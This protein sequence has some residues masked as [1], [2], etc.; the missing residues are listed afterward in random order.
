MWWQTNQISPSV[1]TQNP[2]HRLGTVIPVFRDTNSA[3]AM[4][5][6]AAIAITNN[7]RVAKTTLRN[8][9]EK[10]TRSG[11]L[12]FTRKAYEFSALNDIGIPGDLRYRERRE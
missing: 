3:M 11:G 7:L 1:Q 10:G 6:K 2:N 4:T 12:G 8:Q 5:S 9:V